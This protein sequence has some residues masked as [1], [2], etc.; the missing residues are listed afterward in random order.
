MHGVAQHLGGS[1]VID[2]VVFCNHR[3]VRQAGDE[4]GELLS[5]TADADTNAPGAVC[6][7]GEQ[8]EE[9]GLKE[10]ATVRSIFQRHTPWQVARTRSFRLYDTHSS[11]DESPGNPNS[12]LLTDLLDDRHLNREPKEIALVRD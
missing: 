6:D 4:R 10:R 12:K 8:V 5:V 2:A 1:V 9:C 11:A 7:C 3:V